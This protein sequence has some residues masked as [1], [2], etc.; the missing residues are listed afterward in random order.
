VDCR[1]ASVLLHAAIDDELDL[2]TQLDLDAHV[3]ECSTCSALL[4]AGSALRTAIRSGHLYHEAPA[5]LERRITAA[6]RE[7]DGPPHAGATD[8]AA[9]RR[10]PRAAWL[11]VPGRRW[12]DGVSAHRLGLMA[13]AAAVILALATGVMVGRRTSQGPLAA[14]IVADHIR[15]LMPGHLTD[16]LSSDQ[17]TVKPWFA[18]RLDFSPPVP[19]LTDRGFVLVGGRLDYLGGRSVAALVYRRRQHV[20]NVFVWPADAERDTGSGE[21]TWHGYT[22]IRQTAG[23]NVL[24]VVSDLNPVELRELVELIRQRH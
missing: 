18:G 8:P 11:V 1:Q 2:V 16:E 14:E 9:R 19:D 20:I 24:W 12:L 6:T 17:H 21:Q 4:R 5:D 7:A 22:V 10:M 3:R 15:S 13:G 23:L